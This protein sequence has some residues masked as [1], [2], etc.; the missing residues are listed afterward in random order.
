MLC[1]IHTH[2]ARGCAVLK[3]EWVYIRQSTSACVITNMLYF[4]HC[5]NLLKNPKM[6]VNP[7]LLYIAT[8]TKYD[9]GIVCYAAMTF[10][11][12]KGLIVGFV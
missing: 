4:W 1:L 8:D 5:K 11:S 6:I 7:Q 9:C 12:L 10:C 2:D 3:G